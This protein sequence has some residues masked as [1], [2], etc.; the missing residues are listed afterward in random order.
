M[1]AS[2][3]A[4]AARLPRPTSGIVICDTTCNTFNN[5]VT[6]LN[7]L[8]IDFQIQQKNSPYGVAWTEFDQE[9][10]QTPLSCLVSPPSACI[11]SPT[12][13]EQPNELVAAYI[14]Q[15]K[16]APYGCVSI[17]CN[18]GAWANMIRNLECA[19]RS[20][21]F[22]TGN[23]TINGGIVQKWTVT[24]PVIAGDCPVCNEPNPLPVLQFAEIDITNISDVSK[25][26]TTTRLH[27]FNCGDYSELGSKSILVQ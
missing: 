25:T 10:P 15:R 24:V 13:G 11:V 26:I 18:N 8:I 2:S 9:S 19:F 5:L 6:E 20:T 23:K 1:N 17:R 14:W 22:D 12:C 16:I 27:C 21:T 3:I 7:P 4:I